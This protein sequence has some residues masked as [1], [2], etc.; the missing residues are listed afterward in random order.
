MKLDRDKLRTLIHYISWRARDPRTLGSV[1]LQKILWYSDLTCY[2]RLGTPITGATYVKQAFGPVAREAARAVTE[3]E[4]NGNLVERPAFTGD[5]RKRDRKREYIAMSR[6]NLALFTSE[7]ISVVEEVMDEICFQ[8]T[9][10][11]ISEASHDEIWGLAE[12][13]EEI[14]YE[15]VFVASRAEITEA[16]IEWAKSVIA[17][18]A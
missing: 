8:H 18:A 13:G 14:P 2:L 11:S 15:T 16:D 3:L 17:A 7:E 12:I 1:K 9:A 4:E 5:Y 10:A 6:P